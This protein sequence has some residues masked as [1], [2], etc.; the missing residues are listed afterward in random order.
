MIEI[1]DDDNGKP[2]FLDDK[3]DN[4]KYMIVDAPPL[5]N[6]PAVDIQ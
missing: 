5:I 2:I 1:T 6:G 4:D 3:D